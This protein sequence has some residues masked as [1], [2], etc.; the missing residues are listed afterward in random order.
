MG[1]HVW[2]VYARTRQSY[3]RRRLS[4]TLV[5]LCGGGR[6]SSDRA[7]ALGRPH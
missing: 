5:A 4:L 3:W 2:S 6:E 1:T 7:R